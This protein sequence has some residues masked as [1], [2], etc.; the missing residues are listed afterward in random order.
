M[1]CYH[2]LNIL[3]DLIT[4]IIIQHHKQPITVKIYHMDTQSFQYNSVRNKSASTWNFI[5]NKIK[6]DM[7]TEST[8]KVKKMIKT[9]LINSYQN[10]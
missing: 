4:Y 5:V 2:F 6:T 9:F 3:N 8:I 1:N 7:I 10:Q